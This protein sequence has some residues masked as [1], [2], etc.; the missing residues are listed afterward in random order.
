MQIDIVRPEQETPAQAAARQRA[1]R[2]REA[3]ASIHADPLVRQM[4]DQFAAVIRG[5]TIEPLND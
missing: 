4:M 3:E 5:G 1:E 2:Q